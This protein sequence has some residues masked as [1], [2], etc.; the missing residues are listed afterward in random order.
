M[1]FRNRQQAGQLLAKKLEKY[2]GQDV[3]VYALPR[4]GVEVAAEVADHLQAPLDLIIP[5]KIGHP[6]NPEYAICAVTEAGHLVCNAE[7]ASSVDPE[8]LSSAVR[9]EAA[10]AKRQRLR[11]L[12]NRPPVDAK[13]RIAIIVDD[14]VATGL[15]TLAAGQEVIERNPD[16]IILA[17]PVIPTDATRLLERYVDDIVALEVPEVFLGA[18]GAYYDDF[19]Q[20]EDEEVIALL[21]RFQAKGERATHGQNRR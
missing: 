11:Y 8:R 10:E 3:V 21:D 12:Q 7:E 13:G 19:E 17:V 9:R 14:G 5:R 15:T 1:H 20:V 2:R 4:G 16:R 18:I 6:L